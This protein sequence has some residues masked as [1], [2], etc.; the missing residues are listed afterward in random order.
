[1]T[2][3]ASSPALLEPLFARLAAPLPNG[4]N[5]QP[6][7]GVPS[8]NGANGSRDARGRFLPGNPGGPG[9]PFARRVA[10]FR[11]ALCESVTDQDF[12]DLAGRLLQEARRGDLAAVKLLFAYTIGRPTDAVDPDTLDLQEWRLRQQNPVRPEDLALVV[13]GLPAS[14]ACTLLRAV[15]PCVSE[16]WAKDIAQRLALPENANGAPN[17]G[18]KRRSRRSQRKR[19]TSDA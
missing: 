8:G 19:G 12:R 4:G 5:G 14:L 2:Q 6:P 17:A 15:L 11:R 18:R 9:N 3:P 10:A 16:Q 1:M 13:D 7:P